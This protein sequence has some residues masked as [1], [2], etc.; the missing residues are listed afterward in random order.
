MYLPYLERQRNGSKLILF[1]TL[2]VSM[3][4]VFVQPSFADGQIITDTITVQALKD[5]KLGDPDTR[6]IVIY[7]PLS[8]NSSDK[9][10]P[11]I[12]LLHGFGGDERSLVDEVG[13]QLAIFLI[14]GLINAGSLKEMI[15]VMPDGRNKYGGSF[16]LN[17]ELAGNYEDYIAVELVD[18]IDS[19][20]R[21]ISHREGR[22][23]AGASMGGYGS[24]TLAMKHPEVYSAVVS[25][26][27]P[28]GFETIS[29][30]MIPE[31]LRENL[32]GLAGPNSE[33]YTSY[34]YALS[35]ALSPNLDN[36]AFLVDL[37]FEYPAGEIIE[38]VRQRWLKADPLTMLSTYGV[39]LMKMEGIYI[40]VGDEDL[41]GFKVAADAFHQEL[42]ATGVEHRYD[43]YQ[44]DHYANPIERA[45]NLL[46]FLSDLFPTAPSSVKYGDQL[47]T[48]WGA[49]RKGTPN[50]LP[51]SR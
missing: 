21:T 20:Y 1:A 45:I 14:D 31:V 8:Y 22:A 47:A 23:I 35:A 19:N 30:E 46:T 40:D 25:L 26:S 37:P 28:L 39:S 5:N 11:V 29:E 41:P 43:V 32:D 38:Q 27:P 42:V 44:G 3:V 33:Q 51:L 7:L 18:Y 9:A 16:Y 12:Y 6:D 49:I 36:P 10:Y 15:I 34:M 2:L 24:M 50:C 13:E 17:S 48:I 4:T